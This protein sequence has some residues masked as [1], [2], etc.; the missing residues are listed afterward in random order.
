MAT[1][2]AVT[3]SVLWDDPFTTPIPPRRH[4][5]AVRKV[6]WGSRTIVQDM[7]R[8]PAE[9]QYRAEMTVAAHTAILALVATQATLTID[10]DA[11][12]ANTLLREVADSEI[13]AT[14]DRATATLTFLTL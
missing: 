9:G 8:E 3:F 10:G 6:P 2:G 1:F 5:L 4:Q 13:D 14:H 7:G 12:R 11:A